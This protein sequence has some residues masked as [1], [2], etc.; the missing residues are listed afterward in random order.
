MHLLGHGSAEQKWFTEGG[1]KRCGQV[2]VYID[3]KGGNTVS[4]HTKLPGKTTVEK[5]HCEN[6]EIQVTEA[7]ESHW[8]K[9]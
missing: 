9:S 6:Y 4:S 8:D 2:T 5:S 7:E 1:T 3:R